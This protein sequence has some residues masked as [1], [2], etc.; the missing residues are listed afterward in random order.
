MCYKIGRFSKNR[1]F[2]LHLVQRECSRQKDR[3]RYMQLAGGDINRFDRSLPRLFGC[4]ILFWHED[5]KVSR[6]PLG[7]VSI[8]KSKEFILYGLI[9]S[10]KYGI[11]KE[12]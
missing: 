2:I 8:C 10:I 9:L 11:M 3:R 5:M 12:K 4:L 6:R 7:D 1:E